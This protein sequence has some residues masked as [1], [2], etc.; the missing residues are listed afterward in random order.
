MKKSG[1]AD[2]PFF[3]AIPSKA[4]EVS[5]T[6]LP[7][8]VA[9]FP[10]YPVTSEQQPN[11]TTLTKPEMQESNLASKKER[12]LAFLQSCIDMKA[13]STASFRYPQE[14]LDQLE[15]VL[16]DLK[17]QHKKKVTKNA[18][19]IT[20][21]AYLLWDFEQHGETSVLYQNLIKE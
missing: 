3:N 6:V 15:E 4:I 5:P 14:L 18:L 11:N 2:S 19:L 20:A 9:E 21:L 16:Y 1:L 10:V 13:V 8:Q 12:F 17:K 7:K